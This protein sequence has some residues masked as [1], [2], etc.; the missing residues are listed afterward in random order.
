MV[1]VVAWVVVGIVIGWV[2]RPVMYPTIASVVY[3]RTDGVTEGRVQG[4]PALLFGAENETYQ[5]EYSGSSQATGSMPSGLIPSILQLI[6]QLIEQ[7]KVKQTLDV[8]QKNDLYLTDN[9]DIGLAFRNNLH[10][11]HKQ[12]SWRILSQWVR[13]F[14]EAGHTDSILHSMDASIKRH[15]GDLFAATHALFLAK[16][17]GESDVEHSYK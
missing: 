14:L 12:Q 17:Y 2:A 7:Q 3:E 4:E 5:A 11:L 10:Q 1:G 6:E 8:L 13:L 16:Y 9:Q 15:Q